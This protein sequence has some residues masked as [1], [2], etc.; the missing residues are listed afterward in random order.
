MTRKQW[1]ASCDQAMKAV[2]ENGE[3]REK[4]IK[5]AQASQAFKCSRQGRKVT[6][7]ECHDCFA[8]LEPSLRLATNDNRERCIE[9]HS[10]K[11]R[12]MKKNTAKFKTPPSPAKVKGESEEKVKSGQVV[13]VVLEKG[14]DPVEIKV[15]KEMMQ[16]REAALNYAVNAVRNKSLA[17]I[18]LCV[19]AALYLGEGE[20]APWVIDGFQSINEA[21]QVMFGW[22]HSKIN[23]RQRLGRA[24]IIQYGKENVLK[25]SEE[26]GISQ[27]PHRKLREFLK[28]PRQFEQFL[29]TGRF[30]TPDGEI[31]TVEQVL[32]KGVEQLPL[33]FERFGTSTRD[34]SNRHV[35]NTG[36]PTTAEPNKTSSVLGMTATVPKALL[37]ARETEERITST[38]DT[39]LSN[40]Y[41][42][43]VTLQKESQIWPEN[44]L[45]VIL[46]SDK[47][48][49]QLDGILDYTARLISALAAAEREP[50]QIAEILGYPAED[51]EIRQYA[52]FKLKLS[53]E[54]FCKYHDLPEG[55]VEEIAEKHSIAPGDTL[56]YKTFARFYS[57]W[58]L[59]RKAETE[60]V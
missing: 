55:A 39:V 2:H 43:C 9:I 40:V 25:R 10:K 54:G 38:L 53:L 1:D 44:S 35:P 36:S 22:G 31:I 34:E 28:A 60:E 7:A 56:D 48:Q 33:L 12:T 52:E 42:A 49:H 14:Q 20:H 21:G 19:A 58:R 46:S 23:Y 15:T 50:G 29:D 32:E 5:K 51:A 16:D 24:F 13:T 17:E 57:E 6:P 59:A 18:Q 37:S 45:A 47:L 8:S 3:R 41:L 11:G 4:E 30:E 27:I 26:L